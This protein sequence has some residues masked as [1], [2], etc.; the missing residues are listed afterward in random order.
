MKTTMFKVA[1][2]SDVSIEYVTKVL[3]LLLKQNK[4]C[5]DGKC[6]CLVEICPIE[7]GEF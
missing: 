4:E 1:H 5:L 7:E 3:Q 2:P 6:S